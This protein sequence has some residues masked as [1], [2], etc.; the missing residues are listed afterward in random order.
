M[1]KGIGDRYHRETKY[2]RDRLPHRALDWGRKP[3]VYKEYPGAKTVGLPSP[4]APG[5]RPLKEVVASRKSVRDFSGE[6]LDLDQLS[7]MLWASTG[8]GR[9][10]R[11]HQFRTSPSAGALYPIETYVGANRVEGLESGLY[12]YSI[13]DHALEELSTGEVGLGLARAALGQSICVDA[14]AV[15]VWTA[16]FARSK[17]KYE[18]RGY[19]Y[20]YM[21]A[22][23]ICENLYL[24]A[25]DLDLG[26]CA[27]GALFDDDLN[28]VIGVDGEEES[29]LY[30]CVVGKPL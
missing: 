28:A 8:I 7:Y 14:A 27:I 29:A 20:I 6:P 12:H 25:T 22:G 30:M 17:W 10:E 1:E 4:E 16:V 19:R 11:G 9:V 3:P 23:H 5:S 15:F 21:D 13:P 2:Y 26:A 18:Q 24:A